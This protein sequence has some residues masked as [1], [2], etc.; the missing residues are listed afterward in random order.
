MWGAFVLTTIFGTTGLLAWIHAI[1]MVVADNRGQPPTP[2][3]VINT[4]AVYATSALVSYLGEVVLLSDLEVVVRVA[5]L[6]AL[7][8][9]LEANGDANVLASGKD[10]SKDF[11]LRAREE[12]KSSRA[13]CAAEEAVRRLSG[14]ETCEETDKA[15]PDEPMST[16]TRR[17]T[18]KLPTFYV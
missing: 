2:R 3:E 9:W 13:V 5:R 11:R 4:G 15:K 10:I 17:E 8:S 18:K 14:A 16:T 12:R 7:D 1:R 6:E